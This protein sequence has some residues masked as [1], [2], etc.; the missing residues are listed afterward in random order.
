MRRKIKFIISSRIGASVLAISVFLTLAL[1]LVIANTLT[2]RRDF[3][4]SVDIEVHKKGDDGRWEIIDR[5]K[6]SSIQFT[7]SVADLARGKQVTVNHVWEG[8]TEQGR[9]LSV[10]LARPGSAQFE[11]ATGKLEI[12][13]VFSFGLD[14]EVTNLPVNLTTE[15]VSTPDGS[16]NGRR[17]Q[18]NR[19]SRTATLELV[20]LGKLRVRDEVIRGGSEDGREG[21]RPAKLPAELFVVFRSEGTL[22]AVD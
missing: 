10:R 21:K 3:K 9:R 20:G 2:K 4:G 8:Q 14:G 12:D 19:E 7:A 11:L 17:A 5:V 1:S 15:S 16:I 13:V 6:V 18:I 22:T